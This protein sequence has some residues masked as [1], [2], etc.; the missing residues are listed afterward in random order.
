MREEAAAGR[1]GEA[2]GWLRRV[3]RQQM[4]GG[5]GGLERGTRLHGGDARLI[6]NEDS[7]ERNRRN[8]VIATFGDLDITR[9]LISNS[10]RAI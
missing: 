4:G 3:A 10:S 7:I 6:S 8:V 9:R 5:V 2:R 1:G